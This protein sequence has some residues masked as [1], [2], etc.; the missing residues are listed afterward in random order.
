MIEPTNKLYQSARAIKLPVPKQ[1]IINWLLQRFNV[2]MLDFVFNRFET[3][4]GNKYQEITIMLETI[5]QCNEIK[6]ALN[7]QELEHNFLNYINS[8]DAFTDDTL[9]YK[10]GVYTSTENPFPA[11]LVSFNALEEYELVNAINKMMES[12]FL[13]QPKYKDLIWRITNAP[14]YEKTIF[15]FTTYSRPTVW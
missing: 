8:K 13:Q 4:D 11:F 3:K 12:G 14:N 9:R 7:R 5:K 10:N 1:E 6:V 15:Y 2:S